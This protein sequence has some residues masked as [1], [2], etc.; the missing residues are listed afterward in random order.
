[1]AGDTLG[2]T[3][4]EGA[5]DRVAQQSAPEEVE[6]IRQQIREMRSQGSGMTVEDPSEA[7]GL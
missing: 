6:R 3:L 7:S 5:F 1:L 4:A 2:G